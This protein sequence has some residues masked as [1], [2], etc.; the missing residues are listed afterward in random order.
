M[1]GQSVRELHDLADEVRRRRLAEPGGAQRR[2]TLRNLLEVVEG[3]GIATRRVGNRV[4]D[5]T[6]DVA[7]IGERVRDREL[8][9]V[10]RAPER[11]LVDAE[12]LAHGVDVVG[13]IASRIEG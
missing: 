13:V 8:C 2:E 11:Y 3:E 6:L 1:H 7:R 5:Q 4:E 9:A 10:R 12:R